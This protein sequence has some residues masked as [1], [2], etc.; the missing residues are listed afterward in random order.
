M[1]VKRVA[2]TSWGRGRPIVSKPD[3]R[4]VGMAFEKWGGT[5]MVLA[6]VVSRKK[7]RLEKHGR[8]N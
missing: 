1:S 8:R 3:N 4:V 5:G 6:A 7:E 2:T